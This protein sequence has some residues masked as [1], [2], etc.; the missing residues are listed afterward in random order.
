M[1][2]FGNSDSSY[3]NPASVFN[4]IN[5][6]SQKLHYKLAKQKNLVNFQKIQIQDFFSEDHGLKTPVSTLSLLRN[7][8]LPLN[9]F[10]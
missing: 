2:G 10:E 6:K 3:L 7:G 4:S 8:N 5:N 1:D 9:D